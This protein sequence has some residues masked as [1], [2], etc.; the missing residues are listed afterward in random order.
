MTEE[1]LLVDC[2]RRLETAG[3]DY[4]LVGSMAGNYWGVPRSTH[5]IDFVIEYGAAEVEAILAAFQDDFFIQ[6]ISVKSALRP[7]HQFN[8]L[9]NRSALKVDFFR[10]AGDE[11]EFTRFAR[12]QRI[13]LLGQPAWIAAPEDVL[14]HKLRWHKISP[15]DKQ[16]KDARGIFL[17]SGEELDRDY[18]KHWAAQIEVAD[19]LRSILEG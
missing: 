9:D 15:S 8:A 3:I 7:P 12:R 4:M 18:L 16:L 10:V 17:V 6:E 14:L 1:E 2:L 5:D 13:T 11:Y 19:L